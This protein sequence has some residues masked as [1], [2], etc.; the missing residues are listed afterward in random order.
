LRPRIDAPQQF[1]AVAVELSGVD[2]LD[3]VL[4]ENGEDR[5]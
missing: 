2:G 4:L 3:V 5:V 1:L